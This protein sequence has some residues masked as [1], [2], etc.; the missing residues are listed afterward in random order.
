M[1]DGVERRTR[2]RSR[3]VASGSVSGQSQPV[4]P[5]SVGRSVQVPCLAL[6]LMALATG[7]PVQGHTHHDDDDTPH[8]GAPGHGHGLA[9]VEHEMRLERTLA[10]VFTKS[11][12]PI[13]AISP[14][15]LKRIADL[16]SS[17][18]GLCESR[19]PP[20]ARPRAPPA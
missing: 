9:I 12:T 6:L 16:P 18:E 3:P 1:A 7:V 13:V 10:P 14:A 4:N 19:A 20:Q 11:E 8:L 2:E 5:S 15:A 17:D